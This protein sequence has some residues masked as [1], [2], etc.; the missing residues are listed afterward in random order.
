MLNDPEG[1]INSDS[2]VSEKIKALLLSIW[3]QQIPE[4]ASHTHSIKM[5]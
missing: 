3:S 4:I 5:P 2:F 1:E